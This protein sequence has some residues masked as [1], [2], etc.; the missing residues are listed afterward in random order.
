MEKDEH[1]N[2]SEPEEG[3]EGL[4]D[5]DDEDEENLMDDAEGDVASS[6]SEL[7]VQ[8][9][10]QE[11]GDSRLGKQEEDNDDPMR[12][13]YDKEAVVLQ[14]LQNNP[15]QKWV[16]KDFPAANAQFYED[17]ANLPAWGAVFKNLEWRRPEEIIKDPKF[18]LIEE[19][20]SGRSIDIDSKHGLFA[21]SHFISAL[22]IVGTR[23]V[24]LEKLIIEKEYFERGFVSFQFF[25]NG[26]WVQVI[27]DTLLPYEKE[28]N[29]RVCLYSSCN[30]PQEFWIQLMEKAY[31]KL[32]K[33][34][35]RITHISALDAL[36]DLTGGISELV[37]LQPKG[38]KRDPAQLWNILYGYLGQKFLLG[39]MNQV[40]ERGLREAE[41]G[42]QGILEN[43]YY[44]ILDMRD[45]PKDNLKLVRVRNPWGNEGVWTGPFCEEADD[46]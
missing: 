31:A 33:N 24:L 17:T 21:S 1:D 20:K 15:G 19:D 14:W 29:N 10:S 27:V 34:Y 44:S 6:D 36:V 28:L 32:H 18:M 8:D 42:Q 5:G 38:E 16:D 45:F 7:Q 13:Y 4:F 30:N 46:W 25:K 37:E 39:A 43:H 35:Q 40:E 41:Q 3:E 22:S 23:P 2:N 26:K 11:M 12:D 9:P